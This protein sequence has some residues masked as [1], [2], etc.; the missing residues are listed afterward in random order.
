MK[1]KGWPLWLLRDVPAFLS[2]MISF[3]PLVILVITSVGRAMRG[4]KIR[5]PALEAL[6]AL[7][8]H[9]EARLVFALWRQ[10]YRRLGWNHRLVKF[11]LIPSTDNWDDTQERCQNY[12]NAFRDMNAVVD[13][14]LA[15]IREQYSIS[16]REVASASARA[17]VRT[18]LVTRSKSSLAVR[19]GRWRATSS[20]RKSVV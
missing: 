5:R 17:P 18:P 15:D 3:W 7:V 16:E 12:L 8:A 10:A 4:G 9:A 1:R 19:R 2:V 20:D 13:A 14:Y 11:N 6:P